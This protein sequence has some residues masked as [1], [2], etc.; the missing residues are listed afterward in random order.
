LQHF[1]KTLSAKFIAKNLREIEKILGARV[2]HNR[3]NRTLYLD[4]E[5]YL[6][7]MINRFGI[8]AEMHKS[9]KIPTAVDESLRPADEMDE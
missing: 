8:I 2:M 1:F 4:Q 6:M 5:Q 7:I 3:K 9:K